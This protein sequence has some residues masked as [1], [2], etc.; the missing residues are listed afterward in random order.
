[1]IV[2]LSSGRPRERCC[3]AIK[4]R[5]KLNIEKMWNRLGILCGRPKGHESE[6]EEEDWHP[7]HSTLC[8]REAVKQSSPDKLQ[9]ECRT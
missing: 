7:T 6:P 5:Q 2:L 3:N 4:A 9:D 1:M 8:T